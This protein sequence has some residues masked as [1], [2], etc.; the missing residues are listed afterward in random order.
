MTNYL[1]GSSY[2]IHNAA[3]APVSTEAADARITAIVY[4]VRS[5][6]LIHLQAALF[7]TQEGDRERYVRPCGRLRLQILKPSGRTGVKNDRTTG[8]SHARQFR[9][10]ALR[11]AVFRK[12]KPQ[13]ATREI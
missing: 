7:L 5:L 10:P 8:E 6:I 3:A 13:G 1:D 12:T 11:F 9:A 2:S 4:K